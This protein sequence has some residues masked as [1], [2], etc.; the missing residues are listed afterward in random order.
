MACDCVALE[1]IVY[2]STTEHLYETMSEFP[3]Y[4]AL[5]GGL[6]RLNGI[7]MRLMALQNLVPSA[8]GERYRCPGLP[9]YNQ[10]GDE[11]KERKWSLLWNCI[12]I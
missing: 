3:G 5:K 4:Y 1:R 2:S 12:V 6:I 9:R 11:G 8:K 7:G 10:A